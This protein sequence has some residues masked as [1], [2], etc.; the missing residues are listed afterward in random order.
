MNRGIGGPIED[1]QFMAACRFECNCGNDATCASL[2]E[3]VCQQ[4]LEG[5]PTSG[6]YGPLALLGALALALG[7]AL[8]GAR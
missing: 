2:C 7:W 1:V 5:Y 8:W 6:S 3:T 4:K